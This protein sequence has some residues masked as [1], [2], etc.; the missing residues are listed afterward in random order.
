MVCVMRS[1]RLVAGMLVVLLAGGT[2][3]CSGS[4]ATGTSDAVE[5][6][7]GEGALDGDETNAD[8][9]EGALDGAT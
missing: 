1:H 9:G 5:E 3:A 4:D 2:A 6:P 8:D 7:D